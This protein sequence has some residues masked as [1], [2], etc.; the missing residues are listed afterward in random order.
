MA[1]ARIEV[2]E[3]K[4]SLFPIFQKAENKRDKWVDQGQITLG[5]D[6][7]N[8]NLS[9]IGNVKVFGPSAEV[10]IDFRLVSTDVDIVTGCSIDHV[11][12]LRLKNPGDSVTAI[13]RKARKIARMTLLA[14]HQEIQ[15]GATPQLPK[16]ALSASVAL[17]IPKQNP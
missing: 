3:T 16:P 12:Q 9:E 13:N 4:K 17:P 15:I 10:V 11:F 6:W 1:M 7:G 14:D 5:N 2:V 8:I